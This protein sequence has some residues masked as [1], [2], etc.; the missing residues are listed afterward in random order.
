MPGKYGS[1]VGRAMQMRVDGDDAIDASG[2][3][4][5]DDLLADR[6][7]FVERGVLAHVAEIGREQDEAFRASAPQRLGGEQSAR[8]VSRSAGRARH[9]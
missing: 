3:Q 8:S 1:D 4:R 5:A 9:R 7:A 6:F 2:D